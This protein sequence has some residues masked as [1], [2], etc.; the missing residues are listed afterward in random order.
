MAIRNAQELRDRVSELRQMSGDGDDIWL[1]Q[2]LLLVAE[3]LEQEAARL[4]GELRERH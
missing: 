2:A 3:E 1:R 4:E